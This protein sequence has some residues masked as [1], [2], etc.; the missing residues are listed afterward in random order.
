MRN[1]ANIEQYLANKTLIAE[2]VSFWNVFNGFTYMISVKCIIS[3]ICSF[4]KF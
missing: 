3:L 2:Y 1:V 4:W